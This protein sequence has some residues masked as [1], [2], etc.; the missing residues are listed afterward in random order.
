MALIAGAGLVAFAQLWPGAGHPGVISVIGAGA[1]SVAPSPNTVPPGHEDRF[2][3][4]GGVNGLYPGASLPLVLTITNPAAF[5]IVV[6][7]VSTSV[8]SPAATGCAST[9]LTVTQFSGRLSVP[10]R[11]AATL[12]LTATLS[13]AAPDACQGAVFPLTYSGTAVKP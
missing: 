3:I 13:H 9:N 12:T 7:S 11:S 6:T 8:G 5:P 10:A 2:S 1:A 4:S